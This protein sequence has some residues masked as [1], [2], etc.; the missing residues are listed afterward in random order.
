MT[1]RTQLIK[2]AHENPEL[3]EDLLPILKQAEKAKTEEGAEKLYQRY[4]E[5]HPDSKKKPKDFYE[6]SDEKGGEM[7]KSLKD[8]ALPQSIIDGAKPASE[9]E[10]KEWQAKAKAQVESPKGQKALDDVEKALDS[11]HYDDRD[12]LALIG[13]LTGT[14][15]SGSAGMAATVITGLGGTIGIA[16]LPL[17]VGV[18]AGGALA[19]AIVGE[20]SDRRRKKEREGEAE[21]TKKT[22]KDTRKELERLLT[23]PTMK[24]VEAAAPFIDDKG[25]LDMAKLDKAMESSRA[26][27]S[28]LRTQLIRLAHENP[29]LREDLLP[30][31]KQGASWFDMFFKEK[32]IP[33]KVFDVTDRQGVTH[34]IPNEV[35]IEAIKQTRGSEKKKIEETLRMIDFKNGDVNHYL[36]HLAKGLAESYSGAL[37]F[38]KS[39]QF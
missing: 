26:K 4:M 9:K 19:G 18:I 15:A 25:K 38:A 5:K 17:M 13:A 27:E 11:E 2:L 12:T 21:G 20:V 16:A 24:D 23:A 8:S 37:R 32:R 14:F 34:S 6:K 7:P 39:T 30:I 31:L 22:A 10:A 36:A 3:R 28:S 29:D 33:S 1:L 35:V